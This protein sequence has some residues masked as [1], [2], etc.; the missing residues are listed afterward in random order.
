MKTLSNVAVIAIALGLAAG[1]AGAVEYQ[2]HDEN[3]TQHVGRTTVPAMGGKASQPAAT[4]LHDEGTSQHVGRVTVPAMGA[5]P[6]APARTDYH[7]ENNSVHVGK[8]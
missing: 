3:M 4:G 8:K 1:S 6:A 7:D 2:Y 5:A